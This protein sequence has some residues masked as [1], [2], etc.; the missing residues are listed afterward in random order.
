LFNVESVEAELA[1]APTSNR[2][3]IFLPQRA[4]ELEEVQRQ[5]PGGSRQFVNG[6]YAS[7][8]FITYTVSP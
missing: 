1:P 3:F 7:P 2:V 8:L 5:F 6:Q 4:A